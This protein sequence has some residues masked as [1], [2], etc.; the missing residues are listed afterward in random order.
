MVFHAI[1]RGVRHVAASECVR[2]YNGRVDWWALQPDHDVDRDGVVECALR[3]VGKPFAVAGMVRLMWLICR[4]RYRNTADSDEDPPAM[5]CSWY[6][7]HCY[8]DGGG[9]D[10]APSAADNCTSPGMLE[11][12]PVLERK[13]TL[14]K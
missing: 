12:S 4:S 10:L 5:F 7:A 3:H 13:G 9:I 14:H 11:R 6:V 1:S 2:R 8:R